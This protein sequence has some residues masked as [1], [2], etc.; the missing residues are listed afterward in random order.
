MMSFNSHPAALDT[1][2]TG[3]FC[4]E[5]LWASGLFSVSTLLTCLNFK[6]SLSPSS[7]ILSHLKYI[8]ILTFQTF[9]ETVFSDLQ[10]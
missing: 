8:T 5:D 1:K 3:L 4:R 7:L 6:F 2:R 10:L 9:V